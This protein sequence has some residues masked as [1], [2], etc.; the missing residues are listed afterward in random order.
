MAEPTIPS[1]ERSESEC[2]ESL[3]RREKTGWLIDKVVVGS[4]RRL[5]ANSMG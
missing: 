2:T 5:R 3:D 1:S 4:K